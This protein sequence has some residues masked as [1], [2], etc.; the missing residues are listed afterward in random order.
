[1]DY[2]NGSASKLLDGT[3]K[4]RHCT[5][6]FSTLFL[7]GLYLGLVMGV[8]EGNLLLLFIS[9]MM[10][11]TR[12][13]LTRKTRLAALVYHNP[14]PGHPTPRRWKRLRPPSS[15]GEG[16][17][18]GVPRNLFS[19]SWNWVRVLHSGTLGTCLRRERA[20]GFFFRLVSPAEGTSALALVHFN[21]LHACVQACAYYLR[22]HHNHHNHHNHHLFVGRR[23]VMG[24]YFGSVLFPPFSMFVTCLS[25]PSSCPWIVVSGLGAYF[26]MA[27]YLVLMIW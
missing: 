11:V 22:P 26:S 1:M 12:V 15:E 17:E 7:R 3:L 5:S 8:V 18:V 25:L 20:V 27:G 4:L 6:F 16:S 14:D 2:C 21:E 13:R 24:I 10:A 19:S 23:M 9:W